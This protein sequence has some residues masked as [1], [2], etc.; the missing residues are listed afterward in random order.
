MKSLKLTEIFEKLTQKLVKDFKKIKLIQKK[1]K[2]FKNLSKFWDAING[3]LK[4]MQ[5]FS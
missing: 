2:I 4:K 3:K 5:Y 1:S